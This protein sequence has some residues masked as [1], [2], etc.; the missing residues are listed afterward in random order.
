[1]SSVSAVNSLLSST[2]TTTPAVSISQI[3]ASAAGAST[4]GID[5]SS[6]VAAGLYADRAPERAWEA[7]QVTLTSQTTALTAI[8]TA[9]EALTTDMSSLNTL[10]GPLAARTVTSSNPNDV[11]A[12]AATGTLAG[13]HTIVVNSLAS[14]AAWYSDLASS[15][16]AALPASSMTLTTTSGATLTIP[17]GT[18]NTGDNLNDIATA[19]NGDAA[20]GVTASVVSDPT[21][22]RLA[23]I[24]NKIG[25]ANDFSITSQNYTGNSWTSSDLPTG[26]S[27]G[28]NSV[29][30][31]S[32]AGTAT[33]NTTAGERYAQLAAAINNATVPIVP[34]TSY[35]STQTSLTSTTALTAGSVTSI[36]D[37]S[38]GNTFTY[39]AVAGNTVGTLNAAIAAAVTAGTLSANVK[40]MVTAGGNEVISEGS[41]DSGITVSSNDTAL[42]A[43]NAASTPLRL[44]ATAASDS[45]GTKLTIVSSGSPFTINEPSFGF[46]QAVVGANASLTVDGVP[47]TSASNT[48][49]SAIP[50]VTV[51]LVGAS[52]GSPISLTVA[53]DATQVSNAINQFVT[54]YNTAIGLVTSQFKLTSTT[55]SS[56]AASTGQGVLASD[57]TLVSLQSTMQQALNYVAAPTSASTT[58]ST[59]SDLGVNV[60]QDGVLTLDTATLDGAITNNPAD[61]QNFFQ[62]AALN[63][64]ANSMNSALNNFTNP[65]NGAFTVDLKS[66]SASNASFTTEINDFESG[67]IASQQTILTAEYSK[68][69]IALQQL[70]QQMA[71]LNA[72]LGLTATNSNGQG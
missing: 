28:A 37:S 44:T 34:A 21:G 12:T 14:T 26:S 71:Q 27:L 51:S 41:T 23:I 64:F 4:P 18:G 56:G 3:L 9:T 55:D 10:N 61:V 70:P 20:L 8:Q 45:N 38:T 62:G 43:M 24:S 50:G 52:L 11:T 17:T 53:S 63:G 72:E 16:T 1:M 7:D 47:I 58:V 6:A 57:P 36:K 31:T 25:S 19:I 35:S 13:V 48:L 40:G 33:I 30:L 68:A 46:T 32:S 67:Y 65:G 66:I 5:V 54:D 59:L 60:G 29:V 69:E 22:S 49:T 42:G 39:T 15:P 2:A